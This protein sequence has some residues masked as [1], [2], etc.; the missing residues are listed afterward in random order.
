MAKELISVRLDPQEAD[1]L[2]DLAEKDRRTVSNFVRN[3]IAD[4]LRAGDA[5]DH[6]HAA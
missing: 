6:P 2:K 3:L 5:K 4:T 1:R